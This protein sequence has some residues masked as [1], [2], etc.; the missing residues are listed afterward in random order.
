MKN[1]TFKSNVR[2]RRTLLDNI[3]AHNPKKKIGIILSTLLIVLAVS[4]LTYSIIYSIKK[5]A[6]IE[7]LILIGAVL[8]FSSI[9]FFVGI[10]LKNTF[11]YKGTLPYCERVNEKILINDEGIVYSYLKVKKNNSAVFYAIEYDEND[12]DDDDMEYI[13]I[14]YNKIKNYELNDNLL[15]FT[16]DFVHK[17]PNKNGFKEIQCKSVSLLLDFEDNDTI[18][19]LLKDGIKI[20]E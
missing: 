7:G 3:Y 15:F 2:L 13:V 20:Y 14:D 11:K 9:P 8:I 4:F 1:F 10:S 17:T 6:G 12:F 16:G 5:E 18:I 19:N